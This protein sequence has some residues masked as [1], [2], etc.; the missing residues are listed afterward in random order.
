MLWADKENH[1]EL[2]ERE[3]IVKIITRKIKIKITRYHYPT[4]IMTKISILIKKKLPYVG[5]SVK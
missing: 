5:R 4:T 2:S 3:Q 1:A